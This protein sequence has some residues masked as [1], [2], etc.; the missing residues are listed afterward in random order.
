MPSDY[1]DDILLHSLQ[2]SSHHTTFPWYDG[3]DV[4]CRCC[5]HLNWLQSWQA[6]A[7]RSFTS[8]HNWH[9][10]SSMRPISCFGQSSAPISAPQLPLKTTGLLLFATHTRLW[11]Y[12]PQLKVRHARRESSDAGFEF[13]GSDFEDNRSDTPGYTRSM[14][15][16]LSE[17][18]ILQL[19]SCI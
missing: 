1:S 6:D 10:M 16:K 13:Q 4:W 5:K 3:N 2:S 17:P 15:K 19:A 14:A 18:L 12:L 8:T 11:P 9:A 7:E